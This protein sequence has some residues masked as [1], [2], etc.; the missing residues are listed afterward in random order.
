[1]FLALD[2]PTEFELVFFCTAQIVNSTDMADDIIENPPCDP[3]VIQRAAP[4]PV[5]NETG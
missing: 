4:Q 5:G 3:V 1:M 2:A